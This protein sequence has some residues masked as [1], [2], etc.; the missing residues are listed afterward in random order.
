M[1]NVIFIALMCMFENMYFGNMTIDFCDELTDMDC[2]IDENWNIS[3]IIDKSINNINITEIMEYIENSFSDVNITEIVEYI[4]NSFNDVNITKIVEYIENSF[5]DVN[6]T[7]IMEYVDII[8]DYIE[9][10]MIVE[11]V[12]QLPLYVTLYDHYSKVTSS[13]NT[14][15]NIDTATL[16]YVILNLT[17]SEIMIFTIL[18][19]VVFMGICECISHT[20]KRYHH[21]KMIEQY[22]DGQDDLKLDIIGHDL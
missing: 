20:N 6:I 14:I 17:V 13:L 4:E 3:D 9:Y 1:Y 8:A 7:E 12:S 21:K 10:N 2:R 15:E 11:F 19:I 22:T 18:V 5:S 16:T